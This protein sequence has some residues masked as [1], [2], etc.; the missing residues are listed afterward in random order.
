MLSG[1]YAQNTYQPGLLDEVTKRL[2]STRLMAVFV[3]LQSN[4]YLQTGVFGIADVD[5]EK[6]TALHVFKANSQL[7]LAIE[8]LND[9][10]L[11]NSFDREFMLAGFT[12]AG[13]F[14][15]SGARSFSE[16]SKII[17]EELSSKA[18]PYLLMF[19][20]GAETIQ[21]LQFRA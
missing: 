12:L 13:A 7:E 18:K 15:E 1:F 8:L 4:H 20:E 14:V 21:L 16:F 17:I 5:E 9:T 2:G 11:D 19:W 3:N 10:S 6:S